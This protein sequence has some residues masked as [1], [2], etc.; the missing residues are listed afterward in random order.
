MNKLDSCT[1]L[2]TIKAMSTQENNTP[3]ALLIKHIIHSSL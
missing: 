2:L 1:D 3:L